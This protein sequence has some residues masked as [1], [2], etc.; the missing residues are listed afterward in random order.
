MSIL[1]RPASSA[2]GIVNVNIPSANL[3]DTLIRIDLGGQ[4]DAAGERG[5]SGRL[6]LNRDLVR[7]G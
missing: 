5:V 4:S 6:T 3:A 2:F 7:P 1:T